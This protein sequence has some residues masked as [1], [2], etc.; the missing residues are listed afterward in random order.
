MSSW[1]PQLVTTRRIAGRIL[2]VSR[3]GHLEIEESES[4]DCVAAITSK[5]LSTS[6]RQKL[7]VLWVRYGLAVVESG[8]EDPKRRSEV[9]DALDELVAAPDTK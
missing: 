5:F 7:G 6:L 8:A 9:D 4:H 2:R 3:A 1:T